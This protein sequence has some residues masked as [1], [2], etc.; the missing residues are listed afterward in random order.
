[1]TKAVLPSAG[2]RRPERLDP[3][4]LLV[5]VI[6][7]TGDE[8]GPFDF[9]GAPA[10][11]TLRSELIAAF[12]TATGQDGRWRSSASM[13]TAHHTALAF[14]RSLERLNITATSL[15]DFG[16]E[17]WWTWRADREAS[18]RWPGQV[19][20]MRV[21]LKD[22]PE[23]SPLTRRAMLQRTHKPRQRLYGSYSVAEFEQVRRRATELVRTTE[24]RISSNSAALEE[25]LN[26]GEQDGEPTVTIAGRRLTRGEL[27]SAL[28]ARGRLEFGAKSRTVQPQVAAL[29]E[30][31]E[32]HPTY[33]L[34]PTRLEVISL[35]VLL[36]C[37]RGYNLS[38]LQSLTIP[39]VAS[40]V[41]PVEDG[42]LV[43]H[44]DKP[45]RGHRRFFSNSF[46]GPEARALRQAMA[47][48]D[49]AR[50]CLAGLGHPS[51]QLLINGSCIGVSDH[52]TRIFVI[53]DFT[54]G[55][56]VRRWDQIANIRTDSGE[57]LH[58]HFNRLRLSEQVI[59][60]KSSQNS[61]TVSEDVY[62]RPDALT[63]HLVEDV[64]LD[65][66][67]DAVAHAA[68]TTK[69]R[70]ES[71]IGALHLP[72][73]TA[74][75]IEVGSLDTATGACL[76]FTH[77]PFTAPGN[78]CTASFLMCLACPNAIATPAHLPR[79]LTLHEALT[80]LSSVDP[81]RFDLLYREHHTR[82]EHLLS[83]R[84]TDAERVL[85]R[86]AATD[87]DRDMIERLLRR[88]LDS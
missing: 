54:N 55:G 77:S 52:P 20:T 22:A 1:M 81:T 70:Y 30:T 56:A 14:L 11:G 69:M 17:A 34:F 79:L 40:G 16:P 12:V 76:D 29:L 37:D 10:H 5:S 28:M 42:V 59:N 19:N 36:V 85:A 74:A 50:H 73:T 3:S 32:L 44:L 57:P 78:A 39:D 43:T 41:T 21:L 63:A 75:A 51:D 23:V 66:Q 24:A 53:K 2:Y 86:A 25:Y 38:T 61:D 8:V 45:R 80:N 26:A 46:A 88:E 71:T 68:A 58:L 9:S 27:L 72:A 13:D 67:A 65:G 84:T 7:T 47:I 6:G 31:G 60:R 87:P 4:G 33:A 83:S 49:P 15:S 35:M 62:R 18:N 48:T 82:L 64:I